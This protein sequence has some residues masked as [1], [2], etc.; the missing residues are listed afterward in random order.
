MQTELC[1]KLGIDFPIFAFTHCRDVVAAVTNA[2]GF[3]VLGAVGFT[4][5]QLAIE[6]DWIDQ[7]V[8]DRPYG[9]DIIIPNK[10][11]G[12]GEQ[13]PEK[14]KALLIAAIPQSYR[15]YADKIL[16]DLGIPEINDD[17]ADYNQLAMTEA[18]S[19][20]QIELALKHPNIKL[21]ANALGTPPPEIIKQVQDS[22]RMIGALC[23]S[24]RHAEKHVA[25]G[26]DF[27]VAQGGEG[28]GHTGDIGSVVLWPDVVDVARD[29]PVIAAGG[30]GSGRQMHAALGMGAQGVWSGSIW[31]TVTESATSEADIASLLLAK[32]SDTVRST[33]FTGKHVRMLRNRWT[34]TWDAV[35]TLDSLSS[36][37]QMLLARRSLVRARKAGEQGQAVAFSPAGQIVGR[38]H[39]RISAKDQLNQIVEEYIETSEYLSS[40]L[41]K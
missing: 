24:P 17:G 33:S 27:I 38:M 37:M 30:V 21:I 39:Q 20:P 34:D 40:L 19:A 41:P 1:K 26:L 7:H 25:A 15:E 23:G 6:L 36:P 4:P 35:D 3:G 29:I 10:Y 18:S 22:G 16:D 8:G 9:I 14:L 11:T 28:G 31:L 2:G 12:Q 5:E 13:D 32:S